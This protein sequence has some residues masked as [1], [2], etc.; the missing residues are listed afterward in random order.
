LV[1]QLLCL[2]KFANMQQ[3]HK[4]Q[5]EP[6]PMGGRVSGAI[7]GSIT[8]GVVVPIVYGSLSDPNF[9]S[10]SD[11]YIWGTIDQ[12]GGPFYV[13][14]QTIGSG[15]RSVGRLLIEAGGDYQYLQREFIFARITSDIQAGNSTL[16]AYRVEIPE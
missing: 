9:V 12:G 3:A 13:Q 7:N 10:V 15:G 2:S 6:V 16:E 5:V 8:A 4:P 11:T 14:A 1:G